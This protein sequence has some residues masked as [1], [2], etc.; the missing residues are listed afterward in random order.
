MRRDNGTGARAYETVVQ[1]ITILNKYGIHARPAALFVKTANQF[2]SDIKVEKDGMFV[3]AKSIMGL[4]TIE[5][6]MGVTLRIH[7]VGP[8]AREAVQAL[9]ELARAKFHEE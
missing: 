5:G 6:Y 3:S 9:E 7:A 1:E 8:D 2:H 4:L